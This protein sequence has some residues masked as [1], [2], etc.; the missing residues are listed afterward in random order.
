[1]SSLVSNLN[2]STAQ[3]IVNWVTTADRCVHTAD[4]MQ[5]DFI[6]QNCRQL[7]ANVVPTQLNSTAESHQCQWCVLALT[8]QS[9]QQYG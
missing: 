7:V 8:Q 3:E 9:V 1:M 4:T 6:V 5:L 2:S